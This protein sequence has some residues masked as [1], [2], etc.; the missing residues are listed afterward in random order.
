M[1]VSIGKPKNVS[2]LSDIVRNPIYATAVG[3]LQYGAAQG[4]RA[5]RPAS[6]EAAG[7]SI[8]SKVKQWL[9]GNES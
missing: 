2:G 8:L 5:G 4:D 3:L 6:A 1:P 7:D 9:L